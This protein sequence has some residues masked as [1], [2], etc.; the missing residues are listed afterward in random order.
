MNTAA[1]NRINLDFNNEASV[2]IGV[3]FIVGSIVCAHGAELLQGE[4]IA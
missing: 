3:M 1:D 4:E 2:V